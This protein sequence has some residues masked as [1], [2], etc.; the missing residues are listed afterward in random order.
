MYHKEL[1]TE[2]HYVGVVVSASS[3]VCPARERI[4]FTHQLPRPVR[5][6]EVK[7]REIEGPVCLVPVQLFG[8]H[9]VLQVLVVRQYLTG[10]FSTFNKV[11]P[12]LQCPDD[13]EHLLVMYLV[14]VFDRRQRLG[15]ERDWV[16][17]SVD[18][19]ERTA[20]VA[21]LELSA[22]MRKGPKGFVKSGEMRTGIDVTL[23]F[24]LLNVDCLLAFQRHTQSFNVRSKSGRTC[25]E[26]SLIKCW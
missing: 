6:R 4:Q 11:P 3:M 26:K 20:P 5:E 19:W 22:L 10:V 24:S 1:G 23:P 14:V 8:H 15:E 25:S 12:L 2:E 7:A 9:E 16:P 13:S 17:S 18:T 21:K